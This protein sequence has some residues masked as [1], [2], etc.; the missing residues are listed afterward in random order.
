MMPHPEK[1]ALLFGPYRAPALHVGD[2]THW[3]Y[4]NAEVVV[5]SWTD[6]PIPWPRCR[7]LE[8]HGRGSWT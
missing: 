1:A 5:T 6:A 3:L 2:R 7:A 8:T 4:R